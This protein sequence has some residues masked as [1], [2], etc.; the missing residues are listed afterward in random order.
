MCDR[1]RPSPKAVISNLKE[2]MPL[3]KKTRLFIRN[4]ALKIARLKSCCG[5]LG[6]PGC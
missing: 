5:H 2:K 3:G 6:E 1:E 4:N